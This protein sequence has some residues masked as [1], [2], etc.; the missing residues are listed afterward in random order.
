MNEQERAEWERMKQDVW[1]IVKHYVKHGLIGLVM[2]LIIVA[3]I[4]FLFTH[5]GIILF[6]VFVIVLIFVLK[7]LVDIGEWMVNAWKELRE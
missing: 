4:V 2:A 6:I 1:F 5:P 3:I 7:V